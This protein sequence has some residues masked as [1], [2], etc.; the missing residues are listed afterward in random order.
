MLLASEDVGRWP[1][2]MQ[3][4]GCLEGV[5]MIYRYQAATSTD[6]RSILP[7]KFFEISDRARRPR[8]IRFVWFSM[9]MQAAC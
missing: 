1:D 2:H 6:L 3:E 4:Q 9:I 8:S 5:K 7:N